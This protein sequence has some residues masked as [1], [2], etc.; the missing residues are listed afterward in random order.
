MS[1]C[2]S[3]QVTANYAGELLTCGRRAIRK[4]ASADARGNVGSDCSAQNAGIQLRRVLE[5]N[6]QE[7]VF[8]AAARVV[9]GV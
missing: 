8:H 9:T 1:K 6:F 5:A 7:D 4:Q 2:T 3:E